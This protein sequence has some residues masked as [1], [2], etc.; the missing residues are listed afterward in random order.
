MK[1]GLRKIFNGLMR[2]SI[3]NQLAIEQVNRLSHEVP[4]DEQSGN[5]RESAI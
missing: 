1:A 4:A 2:K 5:C 3:A